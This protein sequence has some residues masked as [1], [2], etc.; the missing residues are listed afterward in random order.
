[1]NNTHKLI[2]DVI[3]DIRYYRFADIEKSDIDDCSDSVLSLLTKAL[4]GKVI[5]DAEELKGFVKKLPMS[6]IAEGDVLY[7]AAADYNNLVGFVNA[8]LNSTEVFCDE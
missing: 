5:V 8:M 3:A 6:L 4:E 1:M 2:E 7:M